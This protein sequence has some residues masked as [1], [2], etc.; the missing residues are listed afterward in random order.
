MIAKRVAYSIVFWTA[1]TVVQAAGFLSPS[2]TGI[3]SNL[4]RLFVGA[5]LLLPV[6]FSCCF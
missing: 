1:F 6:A 2:F 5:F 3:H 4:V